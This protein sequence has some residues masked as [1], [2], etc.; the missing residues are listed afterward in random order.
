MSAK[1]IYLYIDDERD[2]TPKRMKRQNTHYDI[3]QQSR[4]Y[5]EAILLI[6]EYNRQ[7][8]SITLDLDHDL[9]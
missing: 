4:S 9:G 8:C 7:G 5:S 2:L 6:R 3:Y 1:R